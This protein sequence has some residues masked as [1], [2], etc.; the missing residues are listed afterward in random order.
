MSNLL[1]TQINQILTRQL[2]DFEF[3]T[4]LVNDPES[5]SE[6]AQITVTKLPKGMKREEARQILREIILPLHSKAID[7]GSEIAAI[8]SLAA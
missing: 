3:E 5:G 7:E 6:F 8:I 1:F 2:K 4:A